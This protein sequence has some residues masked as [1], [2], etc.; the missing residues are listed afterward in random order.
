M[1]SKSIASYFVKARA[2]SSV[3]S[4][5]RLDSHDETNSETQ[6]STE[7]MEQS[8]NSA[9][10]SSSSVAFQPA[11]EQNGE[12][13]DAFDN[14]ADDNKDDS[15]EDHFNAISDKR[16]KRPIALT[17]DYDPIQ[18]K[19]TRKVGNLTLTS[20]ED[21]E[22]PILSVRA[23][24]RSE[25]KL[26]TSGKEV[27]RQDSKLEIAIR[28]REDQLKNLEMRTVN[29]CVKL[30][31]KVCMTTVNANK[32]HTARHLT[33]S[34]HKLKATVKGKK[35]LEDQAL[36]N[37]LLKWRRINPDLEGRT[38]D[39]ATD[40]FRMETVRSFM[41]SGIPISKVI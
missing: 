34:K 21:T 4:S 6:S 31:C 8:S 26:D 39:E 30:W 12:S 38:L 1:S 9:G 7:Q 10:E 3:E 19:R 35:L 27:G 36:G 37:A 24:N 41:L 13:Y 40:M 5:N 14:G 25:R 22:V 11:D 20:V 18:I 33:S 15:A 29:G 16:R 2:S 17:F 28:V 32:S 23:R